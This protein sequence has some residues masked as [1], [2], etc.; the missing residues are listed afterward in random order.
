MRKDLEK[1]INLRNLTLIESADTKEALR[2]FGTTNI[3]LSDCFI[4]TQVPKS[5][6][7][8]TYD[9]DFSKIPSLNAVTP[10]KVLPV[11]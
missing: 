10:E 1:L 4:A 5:I 8:V 7:L 6:T 3:K 2:L 9:S 11:G